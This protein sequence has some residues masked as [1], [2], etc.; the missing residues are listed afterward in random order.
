MTR[1]TVS[2]GMANPTPAFDPDGDMMAVLTPTTRP[3]ESSSGPPELPGFTAA[4]VCI[5]LEIWCP[6]LV[7]KRRCRA[8]ITPK[9]S[10]WSNPNGLPIAKA[11]WPTLRSE[12]QV[13]GRRRHEAAAAGE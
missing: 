6:E 9:V 13:V 12:A 11:N 4:S 7:G 1:L 3:L 10:D 8:L 2:T 5:T